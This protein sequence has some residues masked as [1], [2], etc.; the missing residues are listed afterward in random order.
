MES[1]V[2]TSAVYD[3]IPVVC[4]TGTAGTSLAAFHNA[5]VAMELGH[6][7]LVR[8]SSVVPPGTSVDRTGKAPVP[9]GQWGDR[10]YCVYAEQHATLPGEQAW[11][12]I[13]WV[14]RLDGG[15][16]LFVEHEGTSE[17]FVTHAIRTSLAELVAGH[18]D[19]YSAPDWVTHGAIC[20]SEPVCALVMAPYESAPW[21]G[22]R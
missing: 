22:A 4:A 21:A 20:T 16:G 1:C 8:L 3:Q 11:A 5:L 9:V 12:G 17:E 13:G 14:Q 10:M 7:N 2:P 6:Y 19:E 18:E 15:G